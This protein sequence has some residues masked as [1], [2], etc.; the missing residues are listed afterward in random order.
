MEQNASVWKTSIVSGIYLAI[1]LILISV[2][3]YV[4]GDPMSKVASYLTYPV[5]IAAV[6]YAQI[7][8]KK[9]LGGTMSYG[10]A[11]GVGLLTV[12]FASVLSGIYTFVMHKYIDPSLQEQLRLMSEEQ[13]VKQGRV[14]EEQMEMALNMA[15]KF[16]TPFMLLILGIFGGALGGL[17]ISLITSIFT[18]KKPVDDF[19]E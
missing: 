16:Q 10:Q 15:A 19:V 4:M 1:V 5:L 9:V 7:S 14:P 17:I 13:L 2:I 18:Q 8:Y 6:V 12:I 3:F 11:L